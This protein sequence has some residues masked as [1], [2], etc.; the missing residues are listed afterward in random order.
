MLHV[1]TPTAL[2]IAALNSE[3]TDAAISI[4]VPTTPITQHIGASR[5]Q[6]GNLVR[7]AVE[8]LQAVDF[9]KRRLASL[10]EELLM[11][12]RDDEFWR[13][14]ANSLAV[15][16]NPD[17]L[18]TF[19]LAN[20]LTAMAE[21][22]DR[23][24]LK[25][26][27]RAVTFLHEAF[28]LALSENQVRLIE[29]FADMPPVEIKV[30]DLPKDA[31]SHAGKSTLNDRSAVGR[32]QGDEGQRVRRM[33]YLRAIDAGL[34]PV[35]AGRNTP[36]ILAAVDPLAALYPTVNSYARLLPSVI[37][38]SPDHMQDAQ[39]AEKAIPILDEAYAAEIAAVRG[40]FETRAG[41]GRTAIDL[42]DAARAATFGAVD[43][44][45]VDMDDVVPGTIDEN[46][47]VTLA[48]KASAATYGVIDEIAGRVL[49]SGGRVIAVRRQD[50]PG[51]DLPGKAT[52]AAILRYP[53]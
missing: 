49:A 28:I 11:L 33:Q 46:G 22:S 24:H 14:Q 1:D 40:I 27:L 44:L 23:F 36:L 52:L 47:V 42:T 43:T 48:D 15:F 3:R 16:A 7:Q 5:I 9:D 51:Q 41:Q 34:R 38:E 8:Q 2:D 30:P 6:Y 32:I 29:A 37:R 19:R 17:R 25:P 18:V 45:L 35:L 26:L 31:A 10:Q 50:L 13:V 20:R 12:A 4:Y 53:I 39:L 21:V